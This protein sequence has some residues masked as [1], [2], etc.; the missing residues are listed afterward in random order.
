VSTT[1]RTI[2]SPDMAALGFTKT[3][4]VEY[5]GPARRS[6]GTVCKPVGR[7]PGYSEVR[8]IHTG[9]VIRLRN[10]LLEAVA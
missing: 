1:L 6:N 5:V 4:D 10:D 2:P 8:D 9:E 3:R 7:Y